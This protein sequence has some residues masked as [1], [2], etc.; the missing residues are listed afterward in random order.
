MATFTV[1]LV[2][3]DV[4]AYTESGLDTSVVNGLS[5]QRTVNM[6]MTSLAGVMKMT[7]ARVDGGT[8]TEAADGSTQYG[9]VT[10]LTGVSA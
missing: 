10:G 5:K 1:G 7:V 4:N 2:P 6:M 9:N 8:F 3:G